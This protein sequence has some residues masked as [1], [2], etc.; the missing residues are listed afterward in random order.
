MAMTYKAIWFNYNQ[1]ITQANR[2]D[3]LAEKL[4]RS[5]RNVEENMRIVGYSW[6]GSSANSYLTKGARLEEQMNSTARNL[7]NMAS[8]IRRIA[9]RIRRIEL[10]NLAIAQ[11][12]RY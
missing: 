8:E 7:R 1:A 2:L 4:V 3:D 9:E 10:A 12:R 6:Q 11:R 5:R